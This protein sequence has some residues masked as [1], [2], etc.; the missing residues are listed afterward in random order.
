MNLLLLIVLSMLL[1]PFDFFVLKWADRHDKELRA[2]AKGYD[3]IDGATTLWSG[4]LLIIHIAF[5]GILVGLGI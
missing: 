2:K 4:I 5:I 1:L 3:I